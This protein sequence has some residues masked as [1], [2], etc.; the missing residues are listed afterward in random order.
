MYWTLAGV[1]AVS[2]LAGIVIMVFPGFVMRLMAV[3]RS[4]TTDH[5]FVI[6]GMFIFL[7]GA[8]FFHGMGSPRHHPVVLLW[9][10]FEKVGAAAMVTL[11]VRHRILAP[12]AL[13]LAGYDLLSG[14]LA[15]AYWQRIR[16]LG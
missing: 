11:G 3:V 4:P 9:I 13:A 12:L 1:A 8:L 10:V 14:V 15:I 5:F 2:A 7:F 16:R 6:I